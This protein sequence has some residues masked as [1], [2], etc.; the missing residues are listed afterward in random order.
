MLKNF[1]K[2]YYQLLDEKLEN[3]TIVVIII[4]WLIVLVSLFINYNN[5][6]FRLNAAI[7]ES[8]IIEI[9]WIKYKVNKI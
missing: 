4:A 1:I 5:N 7:V 6:N 9:N 8:N 2:S 3:G